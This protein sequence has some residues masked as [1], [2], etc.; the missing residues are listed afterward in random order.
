REARGKNGGG[1][2]PDRHPCGSSLRLDGTGGG[3]Q[4]CVV[5]HLCDVVRVPLEPNRAQF[6]GKGVEML[7]TLV[8]LVYLTLALPARAD[9][10][11]CLSCHGQAGMKSDK[12]KDI[13]I[14]PAK[15]AASAHA[16][17]GCSDCHT[18]IKGFPHPAKIA[19]VRC[20]TC[21][22]DE[23]KAFAGSVHAILGET[24]CATCHGS[25]HELT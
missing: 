14:N 23:V 10:Q 16:I 2:S 12:G 15:H 6:V 9:D 11:G 17:L 5:D 19:K 24:A 22:E 20:A 21:H 18:V 3:I 4:H 8:T 1:L 7:A 25:V 13:Y